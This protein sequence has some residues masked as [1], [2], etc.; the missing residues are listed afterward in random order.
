MGKTEDWSEGGKEEKA[1]GDRKYMVND[2]VVGLP[3]RYYNY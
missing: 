1:R 2:F 3:L